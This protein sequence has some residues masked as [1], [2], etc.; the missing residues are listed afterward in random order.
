MRG[1]RVTG[2]G[3]DPACAD[4]PLSAWDQ[5]P[6]TITAIGLVLGEPWAPTGYL[7]RSNAL[8][9]S[10]GRERRVRRRAVAKDRGRSEAPPEANGPD[11]GLERVPGSRPFLG[12]LAG[13]AVRNRRA[14]KI[15]A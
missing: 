11:D 13:R 12:F 1:A 3:V 5:R 2:P 4:G 6:L 9:T 14:V 15:N 7:P 8:A 10:Q